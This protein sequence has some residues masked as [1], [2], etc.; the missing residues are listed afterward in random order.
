MIMTWKAFFY[1][2]RSDF[3]SV[4]DAWDYL[5]DEPDEWD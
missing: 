4:D 5:E 3:E 1:D 2:N